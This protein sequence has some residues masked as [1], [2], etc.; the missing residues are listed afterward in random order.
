[1]VGRYPHTLVYSTPESGGEYNPV[2]GEYSEVVPGEDVLVACRAKP[3]GAGKHITGKG[4]VQQE[5][6]YDL[7]FPKGTAPIPENTIV[8]ILGV[9]DEELYKGELIQFQEGVWS[10]RAWV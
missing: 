10:V 3:N 7:G 1:M 9:N 6:S 5:Y 8:T 2:T 4:G